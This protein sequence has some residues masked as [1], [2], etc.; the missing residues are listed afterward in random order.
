MRE[1]SLQTKE[2]GSGM[3]FADSLCVY[4]HI[5]SAVLA[6]RKGGKG[7]SGWG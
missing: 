2:S 7:E 6:P 4:G 1:Q 5:F 3:G